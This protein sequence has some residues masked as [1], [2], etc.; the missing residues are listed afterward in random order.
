[1]TIVATASEGWD[2]IGIGVLMLVCW[3]GPAMLAWWTLTGRRA[4]GLVGAAALVAAAAT[5]ILA[6]VPALLALVAG[7]AVIA[8]IGR[9]SR[10]RSARIAAAVLV[11]LAGAP[12]YAATLFVLLIG[13]AAFGCAP[14]AY[15]CPL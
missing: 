1:M 15:E 11:V 4:P 14:D 13:V 6:G 3:A 10:K 2:L 12:L 9:W 7:A 8:G 5:C